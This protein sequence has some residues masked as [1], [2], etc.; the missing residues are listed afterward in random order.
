[1]PSTKTGSIARATL[2]LAITAVRAHAGADA[3]AYEYWPAATGLERAY[4]Y[5]LRTEVSGR[6]PEEHPSRFVVLITSRTNRQVAVRMVI[7]HSADLPP[8]D[9]SQEFRCTREGPE[10]L[11]IAR[12]ATAVRYRGVEIP[13]RIAAGATWQRDMIFARS[14]PP[15]V[16]TTYRAVAEETVTVP[17]GRFEAW[18]VEFEVRGRGKGASS[19]PVTSGTQWHARG[20]GM[21]R[22][23]SRSVTETGLTRIAMEWTQEL[24]AVSEASSAHHTRQAFSRTM[25][26]PAGQAYAFWNSGMFDT[27]PF[28]R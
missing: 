4:T 1:M 14:E 23:V 10:M 13:A 11:P 26:D 19:Y 28:T 27:T 16:R 18:K 20:V 25:G 12:G 5:L 22:S 15:V 3:C 8:T 9:A 2:L 7:H 21:V 17:A 6:A 24:S